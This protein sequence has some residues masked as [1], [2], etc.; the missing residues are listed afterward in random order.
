[1]K[2]STTLKAAS[3]VQGLHLLIVGSVDEQQ[4]KSFEI[5][6]KRREI[7][8]V[9]NKERLIKHNKEARSS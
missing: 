7:Y 6:N 8:V 5:E 2:S 4:A 9:S 3:L 1:M